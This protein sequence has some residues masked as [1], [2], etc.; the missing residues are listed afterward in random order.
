MARTPPTIERDAHVDGRPPLILHDEDREAVASALAD[1][2]LARVLAD[3][4]GREARSTNHG[5]PE[6]A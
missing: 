2:L 5:D 6:T 1:L 4:E 3:D